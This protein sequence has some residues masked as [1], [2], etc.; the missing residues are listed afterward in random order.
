MYCFVHVCASE[1]AAALSE[2][3]ERSAPLGATFFRRRA[4]KGRVWRQGCDNFPQA[5]CLAA[6][7]ECLACLG[8]Y[9]YNRLGDE[10]ILKER[11]P[12]KSHA[13]PTQPNRTLLNSV[14][15]SLDHHLLGI[16]HRELAGYLPLTALGVTAGG[17]T[18]QRTSDQ[19]EVFSTN[20][21]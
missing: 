19:R 4:T 3:E 1:V 2:V 10:I 17:A 20:D 16:R 13:I 12:R 8:L 9:E 7:S 21:D 14:S 15:P 6:S 11:T 18:I 5:R